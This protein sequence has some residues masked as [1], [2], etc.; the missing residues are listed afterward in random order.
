MSIFILTITTIPITLVVVVVL[1]QYR[2]PPEGVDIHQSP[3]VPLY[4]LD[5]SLRHN[6][7]VDSVDGTDHDIDR[8]VDP[9]DQKNLHHKEQEEGG[10]SA[11]QV[12]SPHKH[13]QTHYE[14]DACMSR[15]VEVAGVSVGDSQRYQAWVLP[16]GALDLFEGERALDDGS[17]HVEE[18]GVQK[19]R[20]VSSAY[21]P[22]ISTSMYDRFSRITIE[23]LSL[24]VDGYEEVQDVNL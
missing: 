10:Q 2:A 18:E 6:Y 4:K 23:E 14:G 20:G 9:V 19:Y 12:L 21:N 8:V 11:Q 3:N 5:A 13:L 15:E 22:T 7:H 16:V 1:Q 17:R 24:P